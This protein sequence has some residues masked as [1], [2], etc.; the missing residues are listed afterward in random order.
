MD[1]ELFELTDENAEALIRF[2]GSENEFEIESNSQIYDALA[3][4]PKV[5]VSSDFEQ[6]ALASMT[7]AQTEREQQNPAVA[8][9]S[10]IAR[11]R[12]KQAIVLDALADRL[13]ISSNLLE[14]VE[15]GKLTVRQIISHLA[16]HLF[17]ELLRE[18]RLSLQEFSELLMNMSAMGN[19]GKGHP[20]G[21]IAYRHG[22]GEDDS[23][24]SEVLDYLAAIQ[25]YLDETGQNSC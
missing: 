19:K 11:S 15:S 10:A 4:T 20:I 13:G 12:R 9:G 8:L 14:T 7:R 6:R 17:A 22:Q 5:V 3:V 2:L 21:Q 25:S 24:L 1:K 16:P 23:T 18:I